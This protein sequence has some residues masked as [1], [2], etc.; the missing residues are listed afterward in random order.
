MKIVLDTN[1]LLSTIFWQGEANKVI[2]NC[3]RKNIQII[4]TDKILS[5]IDIGQTLFVKN[6]EVVPSE[7]REVL[8]KRKLLII[9]GDL[10]KIL[11]KDEVLKFPTRIFFSPYPGIKIPVLKKYQSYMFLNNKNGKI[12]I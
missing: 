2:E 5:E 3:K 10:E 9:A 1:V 8:L 7:T 12:I 11:T 6:F 4:I